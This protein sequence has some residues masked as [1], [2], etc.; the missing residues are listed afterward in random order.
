MTWNL[1]WRFGPWE[2]RERAIVEVIREVDPDVL[3]L[4]EAWATAGDGIVARLSATFGFHAVASESIGHG[5]VGFTNA[6]LARWPCRAIADEV[7]PAADGSASH[8]RVVAASIDTPW[9]PWPVASTHLDHRFD[10]SATRV[11]QAR[12]LLEVAA[13]WRGDPDRDLPVVLAGDLNA[14]P[15]SDEVRM[16]TGR[17]RGVDGIVFSDVWELAGDGPGW[18]WLRENPYCDATAW[19]NRRIDHVMV[20]WP[21]P[22]PVG[23]PVR[24]WRVGVGPVDV[25]GESVWPSDHAAV[26]AEL[27]TPDGPLS[28]EPPTA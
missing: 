24:A 5:E 11:A 23:N 15:D 28:T 10:A 2:R 21:R 26:V 9:G 25:D 8:R 1:W 6:V 7:L 19:P 4:Q 13:A 22:K 17:T 3:C 27:V 14:V 12:R 18:T 20:S 16:L